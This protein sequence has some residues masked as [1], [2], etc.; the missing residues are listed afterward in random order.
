M[1]INEKKGRG[2]WGIAEKKKDQSKKETVYR[3]PILFGKL[4][5]LP[6]VSRV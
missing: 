4:F 3:D 6:L 1:T 2:S 5:A